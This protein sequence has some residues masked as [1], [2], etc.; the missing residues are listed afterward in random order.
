[1]CGVPVRAPGHDGA[2]VQAYVSFERG[3]GSFEVFDFFS[4]F[5]F[6]FFFLAHLDF[7]GKKK[8]PPLLSFDQVHVRPVR[9]RAPQGRG[10]QV[11]HLPRARRGAAAHQAAGRGGDDGGNKR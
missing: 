6:R 11:P 9:L 1:M 3:F 5:R 10:R 8:L 7:P 4:S 2:A